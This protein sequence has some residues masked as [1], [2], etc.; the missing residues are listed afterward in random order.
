MDGA[1]DVERWHDFAV[2]VAGAGATLAGLLVVAV[3][4][5]V[6]EIVTDSSLTRRAA[7]ALVTLTTPLVLALVILVPSD[8]AG[9]VGS[10]L[11]AVA[12]LCGLVLGMLT[13]PPRLAAHRSWAQWVVS[14]VVPAVLL[15]VPAVLAGIGLAT[16]A[17]GGLYWLPGAV[18]FALL[19]GLT[20]A[21]VLLIEIL[22]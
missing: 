20:Q 11:V 5:N 1:Y 22:R 7:A 6:R 2:A 10:V 3:S 18:V 17:L 8:S 21:W 12:V 13:L 14:D 4:I 15:V 9:V 16:G 19:G